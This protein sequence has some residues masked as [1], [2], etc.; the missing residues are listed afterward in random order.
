MIKKDFYGHQPKYECK[1]DNSDLVYEAFIIKKVNG[2][3]TKK[4]EKF[5]LEGYEPIKDKDNSYVSKFQDGTDEYEIALFLKNDL[6]KYYLLVK[7]CKLKGLKYLC[8]CK[9]TN[10]PIT[11][12]GSGNRWMNHLKKYYEF[13]TMPDNANT[14]I[15]GIYTQEKIRE[16]GRYFS[17]LLNVVNDY[18]W[19]N[20]VPEQGDGG[21]INDQTGKRWKVKDT[22]NMRGSKRRISEKTLKGR[23]RG[24][25]GKN[26]WQYT[27]DYITPFGEFVSAEDARKKAAKLKSEGHKNVI[28][29]VRKYCITHNDIPLHP[30]GRRTPKAWRGKKPK[31]IGFGFRPKKELNNESFSKG[32]TK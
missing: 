1:I 5:Y 16:A 10:N 27:G 22:S 30:L 23:K 19:A 25:I 7:T 24:L 20:I 26:N 15:L 13:W 18:G 3:F 21:W 6:E 31:D 11:Y 4:K 14:E 32:K 8:K 12:H 28:G 2:S 9:C 17:E 29:D